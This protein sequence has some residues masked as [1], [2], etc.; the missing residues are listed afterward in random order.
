MAHLVFNERIKLLSG[1]L[2]NTAVATLA[3]AIIAPTAG[4]LYGSSAIASSYWPFIGIAWF[5]AGL[6]LHVAAQFVLGRLKD[7]KP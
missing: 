1:A 5:L 7:D 2:N 6:S 4:F 3:A